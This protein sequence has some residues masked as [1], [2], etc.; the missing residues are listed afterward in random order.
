MVNAARIERH[1]DGVSVYFRKSDLD[2][3]FGGDVQSV[4]DDI[5]KNYIC[6]KEA[7]N[8]YHVGQKRFSEETV[9]FGVE[10]MRLKG[11][12][13][14]RIEDLDRIFGKKGR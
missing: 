12:M 4:P 13:W 6:A 9:R 2:K 3:L 1:R 11:F 7:L 14:Y 10:K 5:I 8:A